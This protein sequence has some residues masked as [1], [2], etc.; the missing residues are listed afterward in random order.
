MKLLLTIALIA[1]L[2]VLTVPAHAQLARAVQDRLD[3]PS[4]DA[5]DGQYHDPDL[6]LHVHVLAARHAAVW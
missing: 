6:A 1:V 4:R 3:I 5:A 2:T